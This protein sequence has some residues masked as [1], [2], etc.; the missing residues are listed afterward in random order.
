MSLWG[1]TCTCTYTTLATPM[2][3]LITYSSECVSVCCSIHRASMR[4]HGARTAASWRS[5]TLI[6]TMAPSSCVKLKETRRRVKLTSKVND[7]SIPSLHL[8]L[9][10][11][12]IR[13]SPDFEFEHLAIVKFD[14]IQIFA[15]SNFR[16][17]P[18]ILTL[19]NWRLKWKWVSKK[20]AL[21]ISKAFPKEIP[22]DY[23]SV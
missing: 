18:S 11:G 8:A 6:E 2:N 10:M 4:Y 16:L 15:G 23:P 22:E 19:L 17:F 14:G 9:V 3:A 5:R 21:A 13:F 7:R 20:S 1:C 12:V